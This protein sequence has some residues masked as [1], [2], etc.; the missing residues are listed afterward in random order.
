MM[1][2]VFDVSF[3]Q[4]RSGG[5]IDIQRAQR[6]AVSLRGYPHLIVLIHGYNNDE[7]EANVAYQAFCDREQSMV[8]PGRDW[9]PGA[10]VVRV[11]WPGDARWWIASALF[12][13]WAVP[14][15]LTIGQALA[16]ILKDVSQ[17]AG[18]VLTIDCVAHSLGNRLLLHCLSA[19][20][21]SANVFVRRVVHMAAAVPTWTLETTAR[22][23]RLRGALLSECLP[24]NSRAVT[25]FSGDDSVLSLAFP[26]GEMAAETYDDE[27]PIALGHAHWADGDRVGDLTQVPEPGAKHSSYWGAD[28]STPKKLSDQIG[29]TVNNSLDLGNAPARSTPT[30][31]LPDR[32]TTDGREFNLRTIEERTIPTAS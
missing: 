28:K 7:H 11:F 18:D 23:E 5:D 14:R 15:A 26:I 8:G 10:I 12:Y 32:R 1:P 6:D 30:A 13:P 31:F 21:G 27:F 19:L 24:P 2:Q 4:A 22:I 29:D 9:A 3:R 17:Y 25:L 20:L 16:T